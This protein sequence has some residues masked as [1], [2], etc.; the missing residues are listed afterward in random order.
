MPGERIVIDSAL[1]DAHAMARARAADFLV[2]LE[3]KTGRPLALWDGQ[4]DRVGVED[5]GDVWTV[6]WN[7]V[8]YLESGDIFDQL[9]S[10]PIAVPKDGSEL[11]L[12]G[13]WSSIDEM[14]AARRTEIDG[15]TS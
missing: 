14:I 2:E 6:A 1:L 15:S 4:F 13:T 5:H 10:G 12:L 8:A 11:F 7:S 9:L 3:A